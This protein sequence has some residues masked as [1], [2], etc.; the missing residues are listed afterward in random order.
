[1]LD[2][3]VIKPHDRLWF[4]TLQKLK[5]DV[6][7][8]PEYI[9]LESIRT[10]TVPEAVLIIE[11]EKIFFIPYLI[12]SC[13]DLDQ[14]ALAHKEIFD[15][16]SPYGYSGILLSDAAVGQAEFLNSAISYLMKV[17]QSKNI[18]S[19]FFRLHPIINQ[20]FEQ[21]LSPQICQMTGETVSINLLLSE[22]EIW[23]QTRSEHRT[24][25]NRCKRAGLTAKIV[26]YEDYLEDFIYLYEETMNRVNAK[27]MYYFD[28]DYFAELANLYE[29]I[30]L[31]IVELD[32]QIVCAGIFTE[33]CGIVQYHLGGTKTQFLKLS[34]SKL[35]FDR[36]R[37]WA[38]ERGNEIFHLGGG[39]G[40]NKDSLYHFK[41]G[42]S[43]LTHDFLTLRLIA[44]ADKYHHL[45]EVQAKILNI[46]TERL[47]R[48]SF[49]PSYRA[50]RI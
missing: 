2:I 26:K 14:N 29:K 11:D 24:H 46:E 6:Y 23:R 45:V 19:A 43:K 5:H 18:C 38:K 13:R 27:Q 21:I 34:P 3:Q 49:F 7:H 22:A 42:F 15:A 47:Q 20:G 32:N 10:Q 50:E 12:R 35:M 8:L 1:M 40:G 9:K 39:V 16:I 41:A 31:G 28:Y 33:I 17:F 37:F 36:L 4:Q 48:S 25:I 30:H 44:D